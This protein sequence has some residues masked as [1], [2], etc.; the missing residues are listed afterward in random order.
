M[1]H[2][3]RPKPA[4]P[5]L[6]G[7]LALT[8]LGAGAQPAAAATGDVAWWARIDSLIARQAYPAA[9]A[10]LSRALASEQFRERDGGRANYFMGYVERRA[11][12][13]K[14]ALKSLAAVPPDS[15]W[16]L[17]ALGERAQTMRDA[18]DDAGAI[19]QY[20]ALLSQTDD[21]RRDGVRAPLADLY[22]TSGNYAKALERYRELAN[23][24][25]PYQERA[26]FAWGWSLLRL[27]QEEAATNVWK[28]A[29]ERY[30]ASRYAQ[31]VR[32]ALGN[33]LLQRGDHLAASTYYNEAARQG[34][35]EALMS[36]AELLAGEAYADSKDYALA[37]N[38]YRAV[39][40]TSPLREPAGY[41]EAWCTWQGGK[42]ADARRMFQV[43]MEKYPQSPYRPAAL[44]AIGSIE[45]QLGHR[46]SAL[47]AWNR[48]V[49]AAPRSSWA[50][51][52][53]YQLASASF[54][55]ADYSGAIEKG[56]RLEN[57][58]PR[59]KW[60]G[61]TLWMRGESYLSLGLYE[62]AVKAYS[63][64]AVL[65]DLGFLAGQGEQVDFKIGMAHFY[66][67][68]YGEASRVLESVEK[69][70]LADQA[71]FWQAEAR[72]RLGQYDSARA[73]YGRLISRYPTFGRLAE[74]YYGLGW[75]SLRLNDFAGARNGFAEAV[76]RL[77]EGRTR[78]DALY[79]LGLALVDL[80]E[81]ESA[82]TTFKTLLDAS[83]DPVV[84]ADAQYQLA[85]SMY[86]QG[87]LD[88]AATAFGTFASG[89]PQSRLAPQ[90]LIWQGRSFFRLNR[91]PD[92]IGSLQAAIMH[93]N[94]GSGQLYE[95]REQLAAA[96]YNNNQYEESRRVY[97]QLMQM[98]NLPPER[99]DELRTGVIQAHI[100]SGNY[101]QARTELLKRTT[102]T[103]GDRALLQTIAE[104]FYTKGLWDEVLATYHGVSNPSP[105]MSFWAA[106]AL[107]E[108]KDFA[109][110]KTILEPLRDVQDQ[111]LRPQIL[112]DLAK[113][114]R[115]GGDLPRAKETLVQLSE[116]YVGRPIAAVALLEAADVARDQGDPGG[117]TN[118]Y[119]RVAENKSFAVERR[120]QAW[121][122]LGDLQRKNKQWGA[123]LL[124]Y[125]GA[126][127]LGPEGTM[128]AA[129]GGYWG[130]FVLVEMK[131]FKEA[132]KELSGIK[133]PAEA[134]PLPSLA[135]L[136]QGEALE[137]LG[138]WREAIEVY[139]RLSAA[140]PASE[141]QEA[142]S[143]LAWIDQNVPKEMR[144]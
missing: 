63:Q 97:E 33:V 65:G 15:R 73:L 77:P 109:G 119:R 47:E 18:G 85:W 79:R 144:K 35:D 29:L 114:Y 108:K 84:A 135:Q 64:L 75:A 19:A 96:Y 69:G 49:T 134:E 60:L 78:Q 61:P 143:R 133:F 28:Q 82:R 117:A 43:W 40:A 2:S 27:N 101:K 71:L 24:F 129:L 142:K 48:V 137:Q 120:R 21:Q 105:Q 3:D 4:S 111:E 99:V 81:W 87:K 106:R 125:R 41:G 20:E 46:P 100:K 139:T 16:Y 62:E 93:P 124:A 90:A 123:A 57:A 102:L 54:D 67:G 22:F 86:R 130:G 50:E 70:P 113:S 98:S 74:G 9:E 8:L 89:H 6:A 45:R 7:L 38:H 141:K 12:R 122:S 37:I 72:Y 110:A 127:G 53:Q 104:S 103:E 136:K 131:Q 30:P 112:Y 140:G 121:M 92:A 68:N 36:R 55:V 66:G 11:G 26:L 116:V 95:A 5:W 51:D 23:A 91:Y 58:F 118:L 44:Y 32:L 13:T 128:G 107:L 56:R 1:P 25:G 80:H 14:E 34:Q 31:A 132:I 88:D 10:E 39:P 17:Q 52:A 94:A 115:G 76:K 59:S 138:R 83:P 42:F 126:R